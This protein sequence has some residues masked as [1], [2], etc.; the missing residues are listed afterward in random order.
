MIENEKIEEMTFELEEKAENTT[1]ALESDYGALR[2]GRAN[3]HILD[4]V[5]VDYYGTRTPLNQTANITVADARTIV[6][7]PWDASMVKKISTAI[8]E[9]NLGISVGDDG[10]IVRLIFPV[11][12]EERRKEFAKDV[13]KMLED[14]NIAM[15]NAR[16]D[17]MEELK[18]MKKNGLSEDEVERQSKE[19]QKMI[20]NMSV[21]AQQ[22]CDKKI[23]EIMEI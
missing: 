7:T 19:V 3:P 14:C 23:S 6:I 4:K 2:T 1:R 5:F 9:A 8:T 13:K 22:L 15:R 11:L 20:D 18:D 12:T 17:A 21:K 16:R 10:R